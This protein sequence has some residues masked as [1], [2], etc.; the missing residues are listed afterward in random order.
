MHSAVIIPARANSTRF[1]NKPLADLCGKPMIWWVYHRAIKAK[2]PT[3]V[4]VA[5]DSQEI[6]EVCHSFS[7]PTILTS[8]D[9]QTS[10]ERIY[11][12]SK[13]VPADFYVCVNGDEPLISPDL[14]DR[15]IPDSPPDTFFVSNLMT[16]VHS[17]AEVVDESNIKVVVDTNQNALLFSRSPI[18][19]PKASLS[20]SYYKHLGI[21]GYT[22]EALRFFAQTKKGPLEAIEDINE[23]RFLEHG[24]PVHMIAVEA[25]TLSV[26]TPKDL[27]YVRE[28]LRDALQKGEVIV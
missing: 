14:I 2:R 10:T 19:H 17:P 1:K 7:I 13:S 16:A 9:L 20:F 22:K 4:Y 27:D 21:L 18:P 24:K 11:E 8:P 6:S 12:A 5:T 15:I 28:A 23:L 25:G 3:Y 26:D